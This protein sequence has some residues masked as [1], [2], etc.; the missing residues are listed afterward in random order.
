MLNFSN[1]QLEKMA[2]QAR[3]LSWAQAAV[4]TSTSGFNFHISLGTCAL[5]TALWLMC[6]ALALFLDKRSES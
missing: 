2:D 1:K 6:Q 3:L 4:I 5:V